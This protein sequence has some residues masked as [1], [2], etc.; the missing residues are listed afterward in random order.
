MAYTNAKFPRTRR[1][2]SQNP[3]K[4]NSLSTVSALEL[5]AEDP[6]S[7]AAKLIK[8]SL[9]LV[10]IAL[11][12]GGPQIS[13]IGTKQANDF[14]KSHRQHNLQRTQ[15]F[16]SL[17][18]RIELQ[19]VAPETK[20]ATQI[21]WIVNDS[22][23]LSKVMPNNSL[24]LELFELINNRYTKLP[25]KLNSKQ[26][27][28]S[29]LSRPQALTNQSLILDLTSNG[30]E[31][32]LDL[33]ALVTIDAS[34]HKDVS[35]SNVYADFEIFELKSSTG[36]G[37]SDDTRTAFKAVPKASSMPTITLSSQSLDQL[38]ETSV[39]TLNFTISSELIQL[40]ATTN[41]SKVS[42]MQSISYVDSN[43]SEQVSSQRFSVKSQ[44]LSGS[45]QQLE[46]SSRKL[47]AAANSKLRSQGNDSNEIASTASM[48]SKSSDRVA[49]VSKTANPSKRKT[50]FV[51]GETGS[52]SSNKFGSGGKNV[53]QIKCVARILNLNMFDEIRL[54]VQ[55]DRIPSSHHRQDKP[56]SKSLLSETDK[57]S[58]NCFSLRVYNNILVI[59]LVLMQRIIHHILEI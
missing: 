58:A 51:R 2:L 24:G 5:P 8:L 17:G 49:N 36:S 59:G 46:R 23:N 33:Q 55:T 1:T 25:L 57:N 53:I 38:L 47:S 11:P 18:D 6:T 54:I 15:S 48:S 42:A 16:V 14:H 45:T 9:A 30:N 34:N 20:P 26:F 4:V 19:C 43:P 37:P 29:L 44:R 22:L 50:A 56:S 32:P 7:S 10:R 3:S 12:S 28:S 41:R 39:S 35:E 52:G 13:Q 40:L 31:N 21:D 27:S